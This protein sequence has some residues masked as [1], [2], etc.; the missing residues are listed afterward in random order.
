MARRSNLGLAVITVAVV[1]VAVYLVQTRKPATEL[2][3]APL[4]PELAAR[5]NEVSRVVVR[6]ARGEVQL[7]RAG[8]GW[9]VANRDRYPALFE[10][11]K[12]LVLS[13]SRLR[14]L[15]GKTTNPE[16]YS[17]LG[18]SPPDQPGSRA[19]QVTFSTG[20]GEG[21]ADFHVGDIR[22]A[23]EGGLTTLRGLY[24]R[25]EGEE[26]ALLV[27]GDIKVSAI[28][29]DWMQRELLDIAGE[30]VH[31]LAVDGG[32]RLVRERVGDVDFR[33]D[34][35][36][37]GRRLKSQA[38]V[39]S[40]AT[41]L[42]E[43]RFDDVAA[44]SARDLSAATFRETQLVTFEG[45]TITVQTTTMDDG[46]WARFSAVHDAA[47]DQRPADAPAPAL[48]PADEAAAI[49]ART[50]GWL[51]RL[52]GFKADMLRR[53]LDDLTVSADAPPMAAPGGPMAPTPGADPGEL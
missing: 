16:L 4:Y 30:R 51:F 8:D 12:Q 27:E 23:R 39:N 24:V 36:P 48:S 18:L 49:S 14:I 45:L 29:A 53:G 21:L 33:I 5:A 41:A 22:E 32:L 9:V 46:V 19:R 26:Q 1:A 50:E 13:S 10:P 28:P 3:R 15:E 31:R 34:P 44:A 20:E 38:M 52:P 25:R 6:D 43:L 17:R 35:M 40:I 47:A 2:E 37:E 7:E 11:V 42:T